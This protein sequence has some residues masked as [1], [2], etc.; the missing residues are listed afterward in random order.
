[1]DI[2]LFDFDGTITHED[3]FTKFIFYATPKHRLIAGMVLLSPVILLHKLGVFPAARVRP[4]LAKFAFWHRSEQQVLELGSQF[5]TD[6]LPSVLRP[7]AME[8]INWHKS[9]GD[10]IVVVSASLNAYLYFWCKAHNLEL[11]CSELESNDSVLTGH[12]IQG[13]CGGENKVV[14]IHRR[15]DLTEFDV[16][17]AY[18]DTEEDLPMLALA[19]TKYYQWR[20]MA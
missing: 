1:M 16:V 18:G 14:F 13:D 5:A 11:I 7:K 2:A 9:R 8:Q 6:Y 4:L 10:K 20:E 17:F 12:Y 19:Q 15:I 3:A